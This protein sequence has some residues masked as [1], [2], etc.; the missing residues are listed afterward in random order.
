MSEAAID[1]SVI[2]PVYNEREHL[3]EEID[4]IRAS[5]DD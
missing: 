1:V 3:L 4:R 5:L 2:L